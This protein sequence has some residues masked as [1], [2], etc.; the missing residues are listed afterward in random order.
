MVDTFE[1]I[2]A[3]MGQPLHDHAGARRFGGHT[4]R[5]TGARV[6]AAAGMEVN[7]IRIMARH[8]GDTI[9]RYVS[10]AP[11]KSLRADLG[12]STAPDTDD[13]CTRFMS[14]NTSKL[15]PLVRARVDKLENALI[16]LE[17]T[18]QAQAQDVVALATRFTRT[19]DRVY[20]QNTTTATVHMARCGDEGRTVC[21][22]SFAKSRSRGPEIPTRKIHSL[23]DLP[24]ML[25]CE[26]CLPT[27][28]AVA[29]SRF[30]ADL[31]SDEL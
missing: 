19:D 26:K 6:L 1:A 12:L 18:V 29:L 14:G 5:V 25:L 8:S 9:L 10:E 2:G 22:W 31:S 28:R 7:K 15:S 20:V 16:R 21:G 13:L 24:G 27:E 23:N 11:L 30:E 3:D 4:P 17:A